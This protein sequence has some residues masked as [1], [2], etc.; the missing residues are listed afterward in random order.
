MCGK[1]AHDEAGEAIRA[2]ARLH[3]AGAREH[4][5]G[6][7]VADIGLCAGAGERD[8]GLTVR[9]EGREIVF[10]LRERGAYRGH[11]EK[12]DTRETQQ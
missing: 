9:G 7:R 5:H 12:R 11:A 4:E 10:R 2:E 3:V 8:F 1:P 6:R